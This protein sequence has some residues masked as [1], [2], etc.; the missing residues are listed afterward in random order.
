VIRILLVDDHELLRAGLRSRLEHENGKA[1]V[2]EA[3]SAERATCVE[4]STK[5]ALRPAAGRKLALPVQTRARPSVIIGR[6]RNSVR[7]GSDD[8]AY[9]TRCPRC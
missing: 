5:S 8:A 2:G 9:G 1:V 4:D 7:Q 6:V 3:D